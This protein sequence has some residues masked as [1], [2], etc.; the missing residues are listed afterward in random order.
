[1]MNQRKPATDI[2]LTEHFK[3]SEFT[4][5]AK[6]EALGIDNSVVE[7][8]VLANITEVAITLER[9][10]K[11]FGWRAVD[12]SSGVRCPKLNTAIGSKDTSPHI[13]GLAVDF[14][15]RGLTAR[16]VALKIAPLVEELDIDQLIYEIRGETTWVHLGLRVFGARHQVLTINIVGGKEYVTTGVV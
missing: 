14:N 9:V 6:A 16:E 11:L 12:V 3:L 5:S 2:Q 4:R 8:E 13:K 15:I 7:G 1:M 10:R